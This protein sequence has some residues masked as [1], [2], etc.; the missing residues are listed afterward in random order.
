MFLF[1]N[2]SS[3]VVRHGM[4]FF[5]RVIILFSWCQILA[6]QL[7]I[8]EI[9]RKFCS[10]NSIKLFTFGIIIPNKAYLE[11]LQI[12]QI[13]LC[14]QFCTQFILWF[15]RKVLSLQPEPNILS[16]DTVDSKRF[17]EP[18]GIIP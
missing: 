3:P 11:L 5:L 18:D 13:L 9:W 14:T 8:A 6:I 16:Y 4:T 15:Q 17:Q 7:F 10:V 12:F 2:P 1:H